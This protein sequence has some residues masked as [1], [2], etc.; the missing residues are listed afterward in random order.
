MWTENC[1]ANDREV[2]TWGYNAALTQ[3]Y[4][5]WIMNNKRPNKGDFSDEFEWFKNIMCQNLV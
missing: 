4:V 1:I 5:N 3:I 2:D